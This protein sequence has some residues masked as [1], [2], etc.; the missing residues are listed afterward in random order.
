MNPPASSSTAATHGLDAAT[1]TLALLRIASELDGV[2]DQL[3]A[4][5]APDSRI[6]LTEMEWDALSTG[7]VAELDLKA[8]MGHIEVIVPAELAHQV[9][10]TGKVRVGEVKILGQKWAGPTNKTA[11][12]GDGEDVVLRIDAKVTIGQ[13]EIVE[14]GR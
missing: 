6:D 14:A 8:S 1:A 9:E 5:A 11:L 13:V 7:E 10:V 2:T 3:R 12:I 4:A